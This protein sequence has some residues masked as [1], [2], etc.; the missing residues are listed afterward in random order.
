MKTSTIPPQAPSW[1]LVDAEGQNLGR[2]AASVATLL[3]GKHKASFSPHQLCGDQVVVINAA[4]LDFHPVKL[5]RKQYAKHTGYIGHL[6][7]TSLERMMKE[8]PE[9]VIERA[10]KG[11][12]PSNRLRAQM[13]KRLHVSADDQH[14]HTAQTPSPVSLSSK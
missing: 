10:V 13:L 2:L 9:E 1:L 5:Q 8:K 11:M 7:V 14:A 3:R 6:K 4:K 12:L